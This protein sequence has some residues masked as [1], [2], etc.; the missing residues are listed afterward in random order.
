MYYSLLFTLIFSCAGPGPL[1]IES[2][3]FVASSDHSAWE[4]L[5]QKHVDASG[6]VDY[7]GFYADKAALD[8]YLK[9]LGQSPIT[10]IYTMRPR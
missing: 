8:D 3:R 5:L 9:A 7:K 10:L 2:D 1:Q 4:V 6:N